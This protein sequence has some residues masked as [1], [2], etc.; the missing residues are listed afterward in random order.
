MARQVHSN[1]YRDAAVSAAVRISAARCVILLA[2]DGSADPAF[3]NLFCIDTHGHRVWI[4]PLPVSH[5]R[6]VAMTFADH[7][8]VASSWA[9]YRVAID[10]ESG[11]IV[12]TIFAK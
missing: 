4:A 1:K 10:P 5:D 2:Y 8:V 3:N 11:R 6:Y 12:E 7:R 9:G